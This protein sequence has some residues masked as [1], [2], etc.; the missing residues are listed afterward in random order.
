MLSFKLDYNTY[1]HIILLLSHCMGRSKCRTVVYLRYTL[2]TTRLATSG[3][4]GEI[5]VNY[6]PAQSYNILVIAC[7]LGFALDSGNN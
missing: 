1:N 6:T 3:F 5:E 4:L 7:V 2:G